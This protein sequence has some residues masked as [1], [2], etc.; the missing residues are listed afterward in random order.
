MNKKAINSKA[1]FYAKKNIF[2][3]KNEGNFENDH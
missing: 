1:T 2:E 3:K